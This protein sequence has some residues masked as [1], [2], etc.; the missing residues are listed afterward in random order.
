V[1]LAKVAIAIAARLFS[2]DDGEKLIVE[3]QHVQMAIQFFIELYTSKSSRYKDYCVAHQSNLKLYDEP[4]LRAIF[5]EIKDKY[6]PC[7]LAFVELMNKSNEHYYSKDDLK[8][9]LKLP[10]GL[11]K[12][13]DNL[14][15]SFVICGAF[16]SNSGRYKRKTAFKTWFSEYQEAINKRPME[17]MYAEPT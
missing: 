3:K 16:T 12:T 7:W 17:E 14:L 6:A 5:D 4:A 10:E 2:T 8:D 15:H 11:G 1:K 13:A 9:C